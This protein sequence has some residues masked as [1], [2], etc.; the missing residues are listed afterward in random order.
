MINPWILD[1]HPLTVPV[2][3]GAQLA[4]ELALDP[5][6]PNI[7]ATQS[8]VYCPTPGHTTAFIWGKGAFFSPTQ[9]EANTD[10]LTFGTPSDTIACVMGGIYQFHFPP[11]A[12]PETDDGTL[13]TLKVHIQPNG[14]TGFVPYV[15]Q[16]SLLPASR[17]GPQG[18]EISPATVFA[19]EL[20]AGDQMKLGSCFR[21]Y[22]SYGTAGI[23]G[24]LKA[25]FGNARNQYMPVDD[26]LINIQ[27]FKV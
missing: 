17:I 9:I 27:I 15:I 8:L 5:P 18:H 3:T 11:I 19:V 10:L 1:G 22:H 7:A 14:E 16:A 24:P 26:Q 2:N 23:F 12:F 20:E 25:H 13:G 6:A 4:L 21:I